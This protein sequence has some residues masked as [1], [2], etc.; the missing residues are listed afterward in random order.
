MNIEQIV[1]AF[2]QLKIAV[3]GDVMI[4]RY[5]TGSIDRISP[6]APVPVL[7]F[8]DEENRLGG[9]ANVALNLKALGAE[10][11][12]CSVI[13]S[14]DAGK[15]FIGLLD[16]AGFHTDSIISSNDRLT[17]IKT[18]VLASSQH[19]LRVDREQKHDINDKDSS[20][21]LE[22][23]RTL[24]HERQIDLILFQDYNKGVLTESLIKDLLK[25]AD[26]N[27][28]LTTVDPKKK[29][30][31]AFEKASLFKPN[32]SEIQAQIPF[33]I[34]P[35]IED[36][37]K[38]DRYLRD[39]LS[40]GISLITLSEHGAY[41]SDGVNSYICPTQARDIVDV[42]GAGDSVI[43]I[44]SLILPLTQDLEQIGLLANLAGG[45]VCE[46][47]GVIP[48]QKDLLVNEFIKNYVN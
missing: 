45:Q 39:R 34:R 26:E 18:R 20:N 48:I 10:V 33:E 5:I 23:I 7:N 40:H 13:G 41:V 29:N 14:D 12:L 25:L 38:A 4:D 28:V 6:E 3:V 24:I 27:Q 2:Q 21:L 15:D 17:T 44:A 8:M 42:C 30:F 22:L 46:Q 43:S 47:V 31:W 11:H 16:D 1:T 35:T 32:L 37:N 19:L 36:L 9:A